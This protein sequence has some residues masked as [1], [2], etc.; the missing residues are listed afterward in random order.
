MTSHYRTARAA[1]QR[2][3]DHL[4]E[5]LSR[6][7]MMNGGSAMA[8]PA[9]TTR[10]RR[11]AG[12]IATIGSAA[13]LA[14][15]PAAA[16]ATSA[17]P[18]PPGREWPSFAYDAARH[19]LVLFGGDDFGSANASGGFRGTW[20]R[21]GRSWTKQ[22][23]ASSPSGR[24]GAAMAY[25]AATRQL[26]L[27]G[28]SSPGGGVDAQTWIWTGNNW[29]RLYPAVSPRAR[30][31]AN[32]VYDAASRELLLFGGYQASTHFGDTWAWTGR[33]WQHL[34]PATAPPGRTDGSMVYDAAT[35]TVI[36]FG[37]TG[38]RGR[39]LSDMWAWNAK[40]WRKLPSTFPLAFQNA[41]AW[42]AVYDPASK[43]LL[44]LGGNRVPPPNWLWVWTGRSWRRLHPA[45]SPHGRVTGSMIYD[46]GTGHVVLFG[47]VGSRQG[48]YPDSTWI[49]NGTSWHTS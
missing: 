1:S 28:G 43:Q 19:E 15:V 45:A 10:L 6:V 29:R 26:L 9:A 22:H 23:P 8:L 49:W 27:F 33:T 4:A 17:P 36:L 32:L 20:T 24:T 2:T 42:Q 11:L 41:Y 47:G 3:L 21:I 14:G 16:G 7:R 39:G 30:A 31:D 34:H 25:D 48:L 38:T 13:W 37:G 18:R 12:F 46:S 35:R 44:A 40:T 5:G